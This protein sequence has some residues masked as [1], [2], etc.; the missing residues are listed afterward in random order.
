MRKLKQKLPGA[1]EAEE[2]IEKPDTV[3]FYI[4]A[5]SNEAIRATIATIDDFISVEFTKKVNLSNR[6]L[7]WIVF[8]FVDDNKLR[9]FEEEKN[10]ILT[11]PLNI[12]TIAHVFQK[13][14]SN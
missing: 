2:A 7:R 14:N 8:S 3:V 13:Y 6:N 11:A 10:M 1:D 5:S 4:L 12:T 9:I